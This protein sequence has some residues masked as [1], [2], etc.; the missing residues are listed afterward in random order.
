M[1]ATKRNVAEVIFMYMTNDDTNMAALSKIK[2]REACHN[3]ARAFLLTELKRRNTR[4]PK[5]IL[6]YMA[7]LLAM[8]SHKQMDARLASDML[9][10]KI[11]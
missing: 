10:I 1:D 11:G 5:A 7:E 6:E 4:V 2:D 3:R 8:V 9:A